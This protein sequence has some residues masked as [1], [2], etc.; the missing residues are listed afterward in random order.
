MNSIDEAEG[1]T[2]KASLMGV[3]RGYLP[4]L[5]WGAKYTGK[6]FGA[7]TAASVLGNRAG[8]DVLVGAA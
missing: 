4:I 6:G 5:D 1:K 7:R 8:N 2:G 3:L